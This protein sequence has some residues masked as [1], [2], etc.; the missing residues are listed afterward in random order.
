MIIIFSSGY[1]GACKGINIVSEAAIP[2]YCP[3]ES[4]L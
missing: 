3:A 2:K 4:V 1:P